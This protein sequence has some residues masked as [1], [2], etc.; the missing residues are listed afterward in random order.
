MLPDVDSLALFVRAAEL[1]SLSK[2]AEASY[3]GVAATSRR[4]ALLEHRFRTLLLTRSA[5]G[6][7]PTAAGVT[8]LGHAKTLLVQLNLQTAVGCVALSPKR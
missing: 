2:A 5:R 3:I 1:H 8:L 7:E 6:V 4:T